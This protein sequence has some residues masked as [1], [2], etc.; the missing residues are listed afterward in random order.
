MQNKI[1]KSVNSKF[2]HN[3]RSLTV[4]EITGLEQ[5]M[6]E[7]LSMNMILI[8]LQMIYLTWYIFVG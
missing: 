5:S 7:I 1:A 3:N 2:N 4:N 8:K 6:Y